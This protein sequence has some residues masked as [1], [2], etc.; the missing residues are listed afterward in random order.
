MVPGLASA[1]YRILEVG[2][3]N[4]VSAFG[5]LT[6]KSIKA[7]AKAMDRAR[8]VRQHVGT[9]HLLIGIAEESEVCCQ[10][11]EM[12]G[13]SYELLYRDIVS[14][15]PITSRSKKSSDM[16]LELPFE[17]SAKEAIESANRLSTRVSTGHL[18]LALI[19]N[20]SFASVRYLERLGCD[21][22]QLKSALSIALQ[23][24]DLCAE[25]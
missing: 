1:L 25:E 16:P 9:Q 5:N 18:L 22:G 15:V 11:L 24:S 20:E 17:E 12:Q 21:V 14:R 8:L 23:A 4:R 10:L 3:D 13:V 6:Q 19:N 2:D 7:I